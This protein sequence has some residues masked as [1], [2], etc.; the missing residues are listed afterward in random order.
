VSAPASGAR[1]V[2]RPL[3]RDRNAAVAA[4]MGIGNAIV[5]VLM[6]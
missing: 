5:N 1:P 6:A 2:D 3:V 4:L